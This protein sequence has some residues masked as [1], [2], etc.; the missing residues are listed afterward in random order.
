MDADVMIARMGNIAERGMMR[1]R[2]DER[3][4]L[5]PCGT[6]LLYFRSTRRDQLLALAALLREGRTQGLL[7]EVGLA[8]D[9]VLDELGHVGN[10]VCH[11]ELGE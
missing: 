8:F 3:A 7:A 11:K 1:S 2:G 9:L 6:S 5:G 10:D 4:G